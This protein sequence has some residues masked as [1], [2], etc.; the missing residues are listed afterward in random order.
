MEIA[1][2]DNKKINKVIFNVLCVNINCMYNFVIIFTLFQDLE[3]KLRAIQALIQENTN[4]DQV[5]FDFNMQYYYIFDEFVLLS[6]R[7]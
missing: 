2:Q 7:N 3:E 1:D 5:I 6:N 4:N